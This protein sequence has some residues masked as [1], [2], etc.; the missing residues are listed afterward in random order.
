[1][2]DHQKSFELDEIRTHSPLN[3]L[4]A[5]IVLEPLGVSA[6]KLVDSMDR[7]GSLTLVSLSL[8]PVGGIMGVRVSADVLGR[9]LSIMP[10]DSTLV[11][12]FIIGWVTSVFIDLVIVISVALAEGAKFMG[13]LSEI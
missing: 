4:R 8:V 10:K 1:M 5:K 6:S 11:S 12:F 2:N 9:A 7:V 3:I 13:T